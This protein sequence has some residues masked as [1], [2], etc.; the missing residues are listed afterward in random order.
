MG[1]WVEKK[2]PGAGSTVIRGG[3]QKFLVDNRPANSLSGQEK[4]R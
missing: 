4:R 3:R 2:V 1:V